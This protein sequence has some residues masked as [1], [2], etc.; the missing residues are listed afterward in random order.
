[1]SESTPEAQVEDTVTTTQ[2]DA[3][4]STT[5]VEDSVTVTPQDGDQE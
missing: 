2:Q 4:G 5:T 3:D 1:M